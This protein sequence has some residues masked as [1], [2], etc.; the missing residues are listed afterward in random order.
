M[1]ADGGAIA[2]RPRPIGAL[3]GLWRPRPTPLAAPTVLVVHSAAGGLAEAIEE[4]ARPAATLFVDAILPHPGRDWLATAP[5]GLARQVRSLAVD[6]V[7]PPWTDWF[8]EGPIAAAIPDEGVRDAFKADLP[9]L[10]MAFFTAAAPSFGARMDR[11][12]AYLR[13]SESYAAE[14][15]EAERRGWRTRREDLG[16]LAMLSEP[17]K[18]AR[19]LVETAAALGID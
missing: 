14:A 18:L 10:P 11:P 9:R 12:R 8:G 15:A 3:R 4:A 17:D 13:L 2:V 16:H 1:L 19:A 7:V 6:G 5:P